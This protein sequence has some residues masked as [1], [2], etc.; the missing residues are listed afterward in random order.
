MTITCS[1]DPDTLEQIIKQVAK[2]VDVVRAID[3]TGQAVVETE[4]A[5]IK[6]K[7]GLHERTEILQ[8]AEHYKAKVVDCTATSLILRVTGASEKLDSFIT[9]LRPFGAGRAGPLGQDPDDPRPGGYVARLVG[10]LRAAGRVGVGK[11]E[12][13]WGTRKA[14]AAWPRTLTHAQATHANRDP[15]SKHAHATAH[16]CRDPR[17][18]APSAR[19]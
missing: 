18:G 19:S 12:F 5:L 4:I 13:V 11:S 2:L 6:I 8:I 3:H 15:R 9:L 7:A 10:K 1:G 16:G 17:P 14:R